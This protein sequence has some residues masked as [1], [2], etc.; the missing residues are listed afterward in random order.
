M[1]ELAPM[2][3]QLRLSGLLEALPARNRQAIEEHLSY[4]DFLALLIQDELARREQK[5][6][7]QRLRRANFRSHK[8]LEQ[9]DFAFNPGINRALIQELAT[10]QFITE[11]A[12]VLIAGPSGTGKSHLAQ[13]LADFTP[14]N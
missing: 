4:T 3:K 14:A 8:T 6:L 1:P 2:L 9:F 10:G 13:A 12:S 5:R 7:S 11:P